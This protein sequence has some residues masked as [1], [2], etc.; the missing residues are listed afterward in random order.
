MSNALICDMSIFLE[1][2]RSV[3]IIDKNKPNVPVF[4]IRYDVFNLIRKGVFK[5]QKNPIVYNGDVYWLPNSININ[6]PSDID[7]GLSFIEYIDSKKIAEYGININ[8]NINIL[9]NINCDIYLVTEKYTM[10]HK[11]FLDK[12]TDVIKNDYDINIKKVVCLKTS[13]LDLN[14]D[15]IGLYEDVITSFLLGK[16]IHSNKVTDIE[17]PAYD[18]ISFISDN[19][20][21]FIDINSK[22]KYLDVNNFNK[23]LNLIEVTNNKYNRIMVKNIDL[24]K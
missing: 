24:N 2:D 13:I 5:A 4:K 14:Y 15:V 20:V 21:R 10:K 23:K 17:V 18:K 11:V 9:K 1:D 19:K 22:I 16:Q 3:W 7:A 12:L 8:D 6:I